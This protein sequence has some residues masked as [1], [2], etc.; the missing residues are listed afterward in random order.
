MTRMHATPTCTGLIHA[1]ASKH[2]HYRQPH[3]ECPVKGLCKR[4]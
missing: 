2:G 1:A 3:A 4:M